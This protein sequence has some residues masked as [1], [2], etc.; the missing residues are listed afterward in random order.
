VLTVVV[1]LAAALSVGNGIKRAEFDPNDLL[2][3]RRGRIAGE[4]DFF[5]ENFE[6]ISPLVNSVIVTPKKGVYIFSIE[7]LDELYALQEHI[8]TLAFEYK[9]GMCP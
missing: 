7:A 2:I 8:R 3:A 4:S 5:E 9:G 1:V 6:D